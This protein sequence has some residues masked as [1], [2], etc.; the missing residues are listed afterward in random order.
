MFTVQKIYIDIFGTSYEDAKDNI[1]YKSDLSTDL[2]RCDQRAL[3]F[4]P[5]GGGMSFKL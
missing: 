5:G 1:L 3:T 2:Q 4:G